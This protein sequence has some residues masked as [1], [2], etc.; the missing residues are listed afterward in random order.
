VL[1]E[2][3]Q[4]VDD[5]PRPRVPHRRHLDGPRHDAAR[6]ARVLLLAARSPVMQHPQLVGLGVDAPAATDR[7]PVHVDGAQSVWTVDRLDELVGWTRR[8]PNDAP[9]RRTGTC[10]ISLAQHQVVGHRYL[11]SHISVHSSR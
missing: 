2:H 6:R 4:R 8:H 9:D 10:S 3:D 7:I 11:R 5:A 1:A